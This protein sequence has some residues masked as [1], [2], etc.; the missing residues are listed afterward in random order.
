MA[1]SRAADSSSADP[2]KTIADAL[3]KAAKRAKTGAADA[4]A[5]AQNAVPA[6]GRFLS[7]CVYNAS[8]AVSYGV[9]FPAVFIAKSVP[10]NN[11]LV[12]GFVDGARAATDTIDHWKHP[13]IEA[14]VEPR[15]AARKTTRA[16]R[17]KAV[18]AKRKAAK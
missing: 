16:S 13:Q 10:A 18:K 7:W 5:A 12:H 8:Y 11:A 14:S 2:L 9:V 17:P 6:A 15:R 4:T 1:N 3:D